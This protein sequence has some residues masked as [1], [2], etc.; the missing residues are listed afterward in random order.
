MKSV[1]KM[2]CL[3]DGEHYLPVTKEAIDTLQ[4]VNIEKHK[5]CEYIEMKYGALSSTSVADG[6]YERKSTWEVRN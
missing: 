4:K 2:L 5:L 6:Y 1:T 3:V